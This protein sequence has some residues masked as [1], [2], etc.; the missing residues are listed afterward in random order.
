MARKELIIPKCLCC[1][2]RLSPQFN[3]D[4]TRILF[5]GKQGTNN[6]LC[7]DTCGVVFTK[8][9]ITDPAYDIKDYIRL[10]F[11]QLQNCVSAC[12]ERGYKKDAQEFSLAYNLHLK[13]HPTKEFLEMHVEE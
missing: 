9:I 8:T 12:M 10:R 6:M 1:G 3:S 7:S 4:K 5:F 11:F 13:L 2:K